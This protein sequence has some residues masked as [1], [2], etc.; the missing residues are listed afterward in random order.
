VILGLAL[1]GDLRANDAIEAF[2]EALRL[3]PNHAVALEH[4]AHTYE[5]LN[6]RAK[7][8][9]AATRALCIDANADRA[10]LTLVHLDSRE[11][12]NGLWAARTRLEGIVARATNDLT[13]IAVLNDLGH[14]QDKLGDYDAAFNAFTRCQ[15]LAADQ[16]RAQRIDRKAFPAYL[17]TNRHF[18]NASNGAW[19]PQIDD[20][21]TSPIFLVGFPCSGTTLLDRVLGAHSKLRTSDGR[22]WLASVAGRVGN[23]NWKQIEELSNQSVIRLRREC[24]D[25]VRGDLGDLDSE[26]RVVDKD[27]FNFIR[28][29]LVRRIFSDPRVIFLYRDPRD[30]VLSCFMQWF[31]PNE[32]TTHFHDVESAARLYSKAISVWWDLKPV[33]DLAILTIGCEDLVVDFETNC[34][35]VFGILKADWED[36]VLRFAKT[37]KGEYVVTP[38]RRDVAENVFGR[39]VGRWRSYEQHMGPVIDILSPWVTAL[40]YSE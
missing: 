25:R 9:E 15:T 34:R 22:P 36:N 2:G 13:Q 10:A 1:L 11:S 26:E 18:A 27:P 3:E 4:L 24:Y 16:P 32:T 40:E 20:D 28:L 7:A 29:A 38:S 6:H 19:P 5:I 12:A 14:V 33:F 21:L 31:Q 35:S 30:T 23:H 37:V 17:E 8:R 39:S